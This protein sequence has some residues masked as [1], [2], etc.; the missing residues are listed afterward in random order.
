MENSSLKGMILTEVENLI[1]RSCANQ[2]VTD[3]FE[4]LHIA[5]LKKYYNAAD[6]S[7]DYH[8]KRVK[9]D[10]IMDDTSY[11]P[12]KINLYLPTLHANLLFKNLK[13]FLRSCVD[14]DSKSLGF[15]AG[16]LRTFTNKEVI[17]TPV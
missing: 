5:L 12:K 13:D 8:R 1:S 14:K 3:K 11:D 7:I 4:K 2:K 15:Y 9:M 16:L 10:I 17:L 6:V